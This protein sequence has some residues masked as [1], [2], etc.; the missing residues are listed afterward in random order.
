MAEGGGRLNSEMY[1]RK[2]NYKVKAIIS[3][4]NYKVRHMGSQRE[5]EEAQ[6]ALRRVGEAGQI[7]STFRLVD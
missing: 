1:V 2:R 7:E 6:E 5:A 4:R 3:K